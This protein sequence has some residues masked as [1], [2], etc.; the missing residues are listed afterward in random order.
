MRIAARCA[1]IRILFLNLVATHCILF[2]S[3]VRILIFYKALKIDHFSQYIDDLLF[4]SFFLSEQPR[5]LQ[6]LIEQYPQSDRATEAKFLL[7]LQNR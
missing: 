4:S 1:V 3:S 2:L 6:R 7:D 5:Y